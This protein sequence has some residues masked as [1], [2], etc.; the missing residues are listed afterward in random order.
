[1]PKYQHMAVNLVLR[2]LSW[3]TVFLITLSWVVRPKRVVF[4]A[5]VVLVALLKAVRYLYYKPTVVRKL[6]KKRSVVRQ[7][8]QRK[9]RVFNIVLVVWLRFLPHMDLFWEVHQYAWRLWVILPLLL[10]LVTMAGLT[11]ECRKQRIFVEVKV[12]VYKRMERLRKVLCHK[13]MPKMKTQKM[14]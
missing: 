4:S 13:P 2:Y 8:Y 5:I 12:C 3:T 1:M 11:P 9:F 10:M 6:P 14:K 7:L